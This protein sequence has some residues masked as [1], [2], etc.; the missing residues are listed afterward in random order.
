MLRRKPEGQAVHPDKVQQAQ[1]LLLSQSKRSVLKR[2]GFSL[3]LATPLPICNWNNAGPTQL[4]AHEVAKQGTAS[5]VAAF[6][7]CRR[8]SQ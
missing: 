3:D 8:R 5:E 2:V 1:A 4:S 7:H 6:S